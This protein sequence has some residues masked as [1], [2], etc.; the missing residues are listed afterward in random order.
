MAAPSATLPG[1]R[2]SSMMLKQTAATN[3]S[4]NNITGTNSTLYVIHAVSTAS[5]TNFIK[6]YDARN[7]T[8]GTTDP[9]IV[10]PITAGQTQVIVCTE[11][12]TMTNA[13]SWCCVD[14][15]GTAGTTNPTGGNMTITATVS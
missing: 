7:P 11:G 12:V 5:N 4:D 14:S 1:A 6:I 15:G 2:M 8:V 13:I 3:V 9:Q 10:I